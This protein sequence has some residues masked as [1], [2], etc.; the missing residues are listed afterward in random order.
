MKNIFLSFCFFFCLLQAIHAQDNGV[1]TFSIP[2]RNS[3]RFNK[4]LINPAFS[5]AREQNSYV[6]IFNKR[7]WIQFDDAP[8]TYLASYSGRFRENQ[9]VGLAVFQQ[10]EGVLTTFGGVVNFAQNVYINQDNNLTFG[11]NLGFY[12]SGIN[13]GGVVTNY[14]DP[15]L[16]LVPSNSLLVVS[17]GINYGTAFLDFG[18]ALKNAVLYNLQTSQMVQDDPQR[19]IQAHLMYT[20]FIDSNGFFDRSKFSGLLRTEIKKEQTIISGLMMFS[21]PKGV[22][23]QAGYNTFHGVSAGIGLNVTSRIA[24]EYNYEKT[25]G[26]FTQF[27]PSHEIVLAYK[28]NGKYSDDDEEEGS[29]LP[30]FEPKTVATPQPVVK[31][32]QKSATDIQK[33]N[34]LKTAKAKAVADAALKARQDFEA[35]AK[36]KAEENRLKRE[37][38][39]ADAAAKAKIAAD[40]RTKQLA[41]AKAKVTVPVSTPD[42]KAK[43]E[44]Q[45]KA[46]V[47]AEAAKAKLVADAKAKAD[48]EAAK[49]VVN[50][51]KSDDSAKAKLA[52]EAK[53]KSDAAKVKLAADAKAKLDAEAAKAKLVADAKAK[54]DAEAKAKS[55]TEAKAKLAADAKAK[56]DAE[57]KAKLDA[58]AAKAKS[59]AEAKAKLDAEAR[60]KLTAEAKAKLDAEAKAKFDAE[61]ANAKLA[62]EAAKA[63]S[64][65]EAKAKLD[66]EAAKAKSDAEAAKAKLA[67]D[68]KAKLDAEAAKAKLAADAKAKSDAEAKAK[69][70][71]EAAKAKLAAD[72][73]AKSDAEAKAKLDAEAAKAKL[74]ADAKAKSDAEAKAKSDAEEQA[75]L[76]ALNKPKDEN[77]K[78]MDKIAE[79][80]DVAGKT[81]QQLLS[82]LNEKVK[83]KEKELQDLKTEN[84]LSDKGIASAPKPF[85]SGSA[86]NAELEN[87]KAEIAIVN[88][89][90]SQL[91]S[92]FKALYDERIKKVPNK[93]DALTVSYLQSIEQLKAEQAQA[94]LSNKN[95]LATLE[96]IKL[97]TEIEKKRRIKRA[98][99]QNEDDRFA[100]D[101]E[102]LKRIKETTKLSATPFKP[103]DFDFGNEQLNMQIIKN[104]KNVETGY[105]MVYAVHEDVAK[106]DAFL[107]KTVAAGEN[108]VNFFF[109]VKSSNYFIYTSRFDNLDEATKTIESRGNKPY[110]AKM[111]IIKVEN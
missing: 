62:A 61:A 36:A 7:E 23:A 110:N 25:L 43:L 96:Q 108:K 35:Q 45:A 50:K 6:T 63:K 103:E 77:S 48:A 67:A 106:R 97:D 32:T 101:Q 71:A 41:D 86:Q 47:D 84:D 5:F 55:D 100:R 105:Y 90:Q 40:A 95:L 1:V 76:A 17:P 24:L 31:V 13:A 80:L 87:L 52:A 26:D 51:P 111:V 4:F 12:K 11:L 59:D 21:I 38:A 68:A 34:E 81:Q 65:A 22:W 44:A 18:V 104:I 74:A 30:K 85:K 53:A 10:N 88:Q 42:A 58:E 92:N 79:T 72:A 54:A 27:G 28:F 102:T 37:K 14:S 89:N 49:Q 94:E 64:D 83:L 78:S 91:L 70:D 56:S 69:S 20:G 8:Q 98:N 33:E 107:T 109:D 3:L 29:I 46:K 82:Q 75:R 66:A 99:F 93:N 73:K 15:A 9:G 2:V 16:S 60:E 19:A 39:V 57:A